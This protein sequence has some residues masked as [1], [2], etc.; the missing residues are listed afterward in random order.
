M[1]FSLFGKY[2]IGGIGV[3]QLGMGSEGPHPSWRVSDVWCHARMAC[4]ATSCYRPV[5]RPLH[6]V[7]PLPTMLHP[8]H[9]TP[10]TKLQLAPRATMAAV[11]R[12]PLSAP[13]AAYSGPCH[14]NE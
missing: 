14:C 9:F 1:G 2:M 10:Q 8:S 3:M 13:M 12:A 11:P 5:L 7:S 6:P 4:V